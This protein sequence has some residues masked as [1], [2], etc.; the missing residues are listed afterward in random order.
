MV[1]FGGEQLDEGAA[2][3][4]RQFELA[5]GGTTITL[6]P[7]R[8]RVD[9]SIRWQWDGPG[10]E[11][12]GDVE[13]AN[14]PADEPPPFELL[15]LAGDG[16]APAGCD[17][18][19]GDEGAEAHESAGTPGGV[20]A[21]ADRAAQPADG[22]DAAAPIAPAAQAGGVTE[23]AA[24]AEVDPPTEA[25]IAAEVS[26]GARDADVEPPARS[27]VS[28]ARQGALLPE[29]EASDDGAGTSVVVVRC[30]GP[31]EVEA[32]GRPVTTWPGS[33]KA[34]ELL[35]LLA[36]RGGATVSR[37]AIITALW[38]GEEQGGTR[39]Q[40]HNAT[41][42]L[43]R[44]LR[45]ATGDADGR[46]IV[47]GAQGYGLEPGRFRVDLDRFDAHVRRAL[48]CG[49]EEALGECEQA[50]AQYRGE[51]L[52]GEAYEWLDPH[53]RDCARRVQVVAHT[54]GEKALEIRDWE[55]AKRLY[56]FA[57]ARDPTDERA[58]RG[59]MRAHA[60]EHDPNGARKVYRALLEA[61][62]RE[63]DDAGIEPAPETTALLDAIVAGAG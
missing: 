22:R 31:L 25:P 45:E 61:L 44:T 60:G 2:R 51:L 38:P 17:G 1:R 43:R 11:Q 39:Q 24:A 23:P 35:A 28:G 59:L 30:L 32:G 12:F 15:R 9:R 18:D 7:V 26:A 21:P 14:G 55:R 3:G 53:L 5:L 40:L 27:A 54:A 41:H 62:R 52:A 46:F 56:D 49:T 20:N 10:A 58:A 50:L 37:E 6:E 57:L 48:R 13:P 47:P 4:P 8:V 36:L 33:T 34:R 42:Y 29:E 19:G 63:L 16:D